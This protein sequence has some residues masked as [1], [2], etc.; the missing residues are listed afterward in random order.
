MSST[1]A[2]QDREGGTIGYV[3]ART[4]GEA[5]ERAH[6]VADGASVCLIRTQ[7]EMGKA[8]D[9]WIQTLNSRASIGLREVRS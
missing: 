6:D 9:N 5:R 1:Y 7:E 2:I 3:I 8:I 4:E